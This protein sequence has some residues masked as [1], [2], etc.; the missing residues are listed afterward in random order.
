MKTVKFAAVAANTFCATWNLV[1]YGR[2]G[3]TA[4]L[5]FG[6]LC[7]GMVL[8]ASTWKTEPPA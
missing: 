5:A 1:M 3:W 8:W 7:A 6:C 2:H 4:N